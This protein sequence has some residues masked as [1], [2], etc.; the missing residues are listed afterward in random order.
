[1]Q[2]R[3]SVAGLM[4]TV[5]NSTFSQNHARS[6]GGAIAI[7]AVTGDFAVYGSAFVSNSACGG[8]GALT[9]AATAGVLVHGCYFGNQS[10]VMTGC[11]GATEWSGGTGGAILHVRLHH[12]ICCPCMAWRGRRMGS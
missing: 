1:M 2:V 11:D 12:I 5:A 8:G 4:P 9:T 10:T 6:R 7:T 3:S